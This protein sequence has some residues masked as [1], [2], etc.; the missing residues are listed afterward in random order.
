MENGSRLKD[1]Y[2]KK[3]VEKT[4]ESKVNIFKFKKKFDLEFKEKFD[5]GP[6]CFSLSLKYK[7]SLP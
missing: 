7:F 6:L 3:S 1:L 4:V 5:L 2:F